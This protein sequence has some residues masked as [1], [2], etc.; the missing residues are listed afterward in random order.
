MPTLTLPSV[1]PGV[2]V[3]S[4]GRRFRRRTDDGR[5]PALLAPDGRAP[6][7]PV[8]ELELLRLLLLVIAHGVGAASAGITRAPRN[9]VEPAAHHALTAR[10]RQV[11]TMV[12]D[13]RPT[14]WI[15]AQLA[16]SVRTVEQHRASIMKRSGCGSIAQLVRWALAQG[17]D[18]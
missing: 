8:A 15:A 17:I 3:V 9:Q 4:P 10:Q 18:A 14:K 13:G 2:A 5:Y 7:S 16:I 11:L 1:R 12:V 6:S